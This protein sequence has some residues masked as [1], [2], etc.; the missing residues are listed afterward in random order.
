VIDLHVEEVVDTPEASTLRWRL[1]E[2][3]PANP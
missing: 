2:P 3:S 1:L